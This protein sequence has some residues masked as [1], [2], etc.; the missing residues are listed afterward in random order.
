MT[1]TAPTLHWEN[2]PWASASAASREL[3][4]DELRFAAKIDSEFT[5]TRELARAKEFVGQERALALSNWA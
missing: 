5:S 4:A 2:E 1:Q 3:S